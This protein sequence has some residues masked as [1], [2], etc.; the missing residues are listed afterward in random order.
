MNSTQVQNPIIFRS[1]FTEAQTGQGLLDTHFLFINLILRS[2]AEAGNDLDWE[3]NFINALKLCVVTAD[4]TDILL[5][6]SMLPK[7]ALKK[8]FQSKFVKTRDIHDIFKNAFDATI[9]SSSGI[10]LPES[11]NKERLVKYLV[12]YWNVPVLDCFTSAKS[13]LFIKEGDQEDQGRNIF[14]EATIN[15]K[16]AILKDAI[17]SQGL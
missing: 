6:C 9:Q 4:T 8:K 7:A 5:D 3:E 15:N 11:A 1:L 17:S 2:Y 12:N 13:A 14:L 16:S 10:S